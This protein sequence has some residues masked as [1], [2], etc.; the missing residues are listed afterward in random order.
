METCLMRIKLIVNKLNLIK[1][2]ER[3]FKNDINEYI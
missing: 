2:I 1:V 3:Y